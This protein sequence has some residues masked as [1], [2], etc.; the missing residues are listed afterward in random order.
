M[1]RPLLAIAIPSLNRSHMLDAVLADMVSTCEALS[2]PIFVSDNCS[3]DATPAVCARWAATYEGFRFQRHP[4]RV[5][6]GNSLMSAMEMSDAEYTWLAGDDDYLVPDGI[7]AVVEC[8]ASRSP[9][10]LVVRTVEVPRANF[11]AL[12]SPLGPQLEEVLA[13]E[14]RGSGVREYHAADQF[15]AEKHIILPAPSVIYPTDQCLATDYA[16]YLETHHAHIG[17]LFEALA[18]LQTERGG[19]DIL[20]LE[21]VCS[22]SLTVHHDQGKDQWSD[23]FHYLAV[24][25]FPKWLSLLPPL[26]DPHIPIVEDHLRHIFR[27]VLNRDAEQPRAGPKQ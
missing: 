13:S 15:F 25:G 3:E 12:D 22:V 4:N 2:I 10:A 14:T 8:L 26:Y 9:D 1:A 19:V 11:A 7:R 6:F 16:P 5:P 20:E 27:G 21:Q 17:T 18:T 24:E 23:V